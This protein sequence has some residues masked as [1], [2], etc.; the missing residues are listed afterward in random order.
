MFDFEF[1]IALLLHF[2]IQYG[3]LVS[4]V[5]SIIFESLRIRF[6][7]FLYF[8][9]KKYIMLQNGDKINSF[10]TTVLTMSRAND[11]RGKSYSFVLKRR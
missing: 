11:G 8:F 7:R 4:F 1:W 6:L 5:V 10:E 2:W 3:L 9:I